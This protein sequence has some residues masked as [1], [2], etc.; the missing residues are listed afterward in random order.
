M[1]M[2]S[3][4]RALNH[5][6]LAS[7]GTL[8]L[9]C[10]SVINV[11]AQQGTPPVPPP[12]QASTSQA[13][14]APGS[15]KENLGPTADSIRPYRPYNRDPFKKPLKPKTPKDKAKQIALQLGYPAIEARRAEFRQKVVEFRNRGLAEPEPVMQY[16]VNELDV[17]GVFRDERGYGAFVKAQPTGTMLFLRTGTRC[18]NGEV[19]RIEGDEAGA[20]RVMFREFFKI[21]QNG[22]AVTQERMVTKVPSVGAAK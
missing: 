10:A 6:L 18:Y 20:S 4:N 21:E 19:V 13:Q 17:T 1:K 14:P 8:L 5:R 9:L 7:L 11:T 2:T 16:L 15:V 12:A 22:K 3:T